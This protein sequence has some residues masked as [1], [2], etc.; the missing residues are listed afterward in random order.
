VAK[1]A[2]ADQ[3]DSSKQMVPFQPLEEKG[4][5]ATRKAKDHLALPAATATQEQQLMVEQIHQTCLTKYPVLS[6]KWNT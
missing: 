2:P 3:P 6:K 4:K 1:R 5:P